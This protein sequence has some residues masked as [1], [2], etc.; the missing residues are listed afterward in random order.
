MSLNRFSQ[1]SR[2]LLQSFS[3][4]CSV[5][6]SLD[7]RI[8]LTQ[9]SAARLLLS[10]CSGRNAAILR[11]AAVASSCSPCSI[12][13]IATSMRAAIADAVMSLHPFTLMLPLI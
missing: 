11:S 9:S 5:L 4:L 6:S 8:P 7:E 2:H 1:E 3:T 13:S 10:V 12:L